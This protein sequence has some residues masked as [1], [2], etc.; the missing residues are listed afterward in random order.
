MGLLDFL[1]KNELKQIE[2]LKSLLVKYEPI[3]NIN[4]EAENIQAEVLKLRSEIT[5]LNANYHVALETYKKIR[6]E[7]EL[8]E[9]KIDLIEFGIHTPVYE[10][11]KSD[12]YRSEQ[13]KV[14][15]KQK[16]LIKDDRA[17]ICSTNW[18]VE[19]SEAKGRKI[20]QVY[21]KL[22]LRAFNGEA[23]VMIAK[24]RWNN[25]NQMKDRLEKAFESINKLGS[26][27]NVFIN[28]QYFT[29]K[30]QQLI[31]EYEFQAKKQEEKE[32]MKAIQD[33]LREEEKARRDFEKAQREAEK[34][35]TMFQKAIERV[36]R[37]FEQ[38]SG[39][40]TLELQNQITELESALKA[41]QEKKER[42]LSMAQQTKRG[43]VYI[44]SNIGA[45]GEDVFKIGMTRRL[46]PLDRVRELGDASVPFGFDVH[47]LIYSDEARTLEYELHKAFAHK[48]VN[49]LNYRKEF[50]KVP[51]KEIEEKI[52]ELGFEG[53][54][55]TVPEA[56]E[57]RETLTIL[58]KLN[59][60]DAAET[61]E[62]IINKEFP[63]DLDS[64]W[65]ANAE[66]VGSTSDE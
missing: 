17:A 20:V 52:Q 9:N 18:T 51:L 29:L 8:Y 32:A 33:E 12:D 64:L 55:T 39:A 36:R 44:I 65:S 50:F 14:I 16:Q 45:F 15:E 62:E 53:E 4:A 30:V 66:R 54:F 19:G 38:S 22:M 59:E 5:T 7:V 48:K 3:K 23:D 2:Q 47:A 42:A 6:S 31:L 40:N 21:K 56:M 26:G 25:I 28:K 24:V 10:F 43:Y 13:M 41:A 61:L 63:S 35:E 60:T 57:F 34:E 11:E 37:E 49:M 1:K 27:F 46:E 58:D